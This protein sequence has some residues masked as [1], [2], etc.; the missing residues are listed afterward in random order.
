MDKGGPEAEMHWNRPQFPTLT[1]PAATLSRRERGLK[2]PLRV[3]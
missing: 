3:V 2:R 1:R